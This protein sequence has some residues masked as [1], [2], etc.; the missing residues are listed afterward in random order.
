MN[1]EKTREQIV[2]Q[3]VDSRLWAEVKE[4]VTVDDKTVSVEEFNALFQAPAAENSAE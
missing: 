2:A 4:A 1:N 3:A